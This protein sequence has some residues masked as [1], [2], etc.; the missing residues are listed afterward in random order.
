MQ[1]SVVVMYFKSSGEATTAPRRCP[2]MAYDLE[3]EKRWTTFDRQDQDVGNTPVCEEE[4]SWC[5]GKC[6]T[7]SRYVSSITSARLFSRAS[8]ANCA[9]SAGE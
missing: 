2:G 6:S 4:K 5:G 7:K 3:N 9:M 1:S 8:S